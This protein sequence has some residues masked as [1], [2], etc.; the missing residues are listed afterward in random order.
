MNNQSKYPPTHYD[1]AILVRY[2]KSTELA[3][4]YNQLDLS[5]GRA[6]QFFINRVL[7]H[8]FG[9]DPLPD[10]SPTLAI[11]DG[12]IRESTSSGN[13]GVVLTRPGYHTPSSTP[14]SPL[15]SPT[16][17][18]YEPRSPSP[19]FSDDPKSPSPI[20]KEEEEEED[21]KLPAVATPAPTGSSGNPIELDCYDLFDPPSCHQVA[22]NYAT[23]VSTVTSPRRHGVSY[24][25]RTY[26]RP[27]RSHITSGVTSIRPNPASTLLAMRE[28][29]IG[30]VTNPPAAE[31]KSPPEEAGGTVP[32]NIC[33]ICRKNERTHCFPSCGH[34]VGCEVC[35][36][37][38]LYTPVECELCAMAHH[39][40]CPIC[41]QYVHGKLRV[42]IP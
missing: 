10:Y 20:K 23:A 22:A 13:H 32:H 18:A 16:S 37:R 38:I 5:D 14:T 11:I 30:Q 2:L 39:P 1:F 31:L 21:T 3:N 41:R 24:G 26:S 40:Q 33:C 7:K 34:L 19:L 9:S 42:F 17:P 35:M 6:I 28:Q 27:S 29:P 36:D 12:L 25:P 4:D 15:Y 8:N